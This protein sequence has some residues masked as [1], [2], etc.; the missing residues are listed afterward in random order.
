MTTTPQGKPPREFWIFPNEPEEDDADFY[1]PSAAD[2]YF[3]DALT[4]HPRQ[5]DLK[6]Q[7][8]AIHVIEYSAYRELKQVIAYREETICELRNTIKTERERAERAEREINVLK[9][10]VKQSCDNVLPLMN[11]NS[12]LKEKLARAEKQIEFA[13]AQMKSAEKTAEHRFEINAALRTR[14]EKLREALV[15]V[16]DSANDNHIASNEYNNAFDPFGITQEA[17]TADDALEKKGDGG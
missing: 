9:N 2:L 15:K 14:I 12:E 11:E 7:A 10:I 3:G 13:T 1:E 17:L 6:W 4:E 5:G 8:S 16:N